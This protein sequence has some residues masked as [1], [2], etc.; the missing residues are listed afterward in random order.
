MPEVRFADGLPRRRLGVGA[1][2][3]AEVYIEAPWLVDG[4]C[5]YTEHPE[6]FG[7]ED[8]VKCPRPAVYEMLSYHMPP[9]MACVEHT[10]WAR[11]RYAALVTSVSPLRGVT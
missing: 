5:G 6:P 9:S 3:T 8:V 7:A 10:A 4:E 2:V 1:P 11:V